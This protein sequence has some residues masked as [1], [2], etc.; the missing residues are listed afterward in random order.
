MNS[1]RSIVNL[2][3]SKGEFNDMKKEQHFIQEVVDHSPK[4]G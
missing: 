2:T 4:D 3:T 1:K